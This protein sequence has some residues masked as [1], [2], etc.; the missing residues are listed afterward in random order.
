VVNTFGGTWFTKN[1]T[2]QVDA[3]PFQQA[4]NF[5]INLV[6]QYGESGASQSGFTECLNDFQQG[7]VAM[8]Y[9]ATSAAGSLDGSGSPVAGKVGYVPAPVD[10]TKASGWLYTW[11]WAI[12]KASKNQ[13]AA[14]KF[15]SWASGKDY[16]ELV[17]KQVG[18][19][20]VPAGKRASTYQNPDYLKESA[21]F[22]APTKAAIEAA[23]P[24]NPGVQKRPAIGIQFVDIPEFPDLG[25]QVSQYI[26][27]AI[28]G[29]TSVDSALNKG[30]KL[31]SD[32]AERYRSRQN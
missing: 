23:D 4:T 9:D 16:E 21:A 8:W 2:A 11:A 1:W 22:A 13:A 28:A 31:A 7:K 30:Q 10:K 26:S 12:E 18:W 19:S 17:G 27:S 14:W 6:K 5:Y 20:A 15:I 29:K 32:V 3:A 25:T 24:S